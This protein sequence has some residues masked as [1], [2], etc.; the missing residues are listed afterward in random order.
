[1]ILDRS[2]PPEFT[3]PEDISLRTPDRKVLPNASTYYHIPTPAIEAVKIEFLGKGSRAS[4]PL[5]QALLP[6]FTLQMLTDGTDKLNHQQIA[7]RFDFHASEFQ[8]IVTFGQ[9]G[10]SLISTKKHVFEVLPL[11]LELVH[12]AVF[13]EEILEKKKSQRRI[14][15]QLEQKKTSAR[16]SKLFR[17]CL[18]GTNHPYGV[19]VTEDFLDEIT[20]DR[21]QTHFQ[22]F[23]WQDLE[24][25]VSGNF[26]DRELSQLE[27]FLNQFPVR[28]RFSDSPQPEQ[29]VKATLYEER[30][31]A[32]QTSLR[33]GKS[34]IPK[35][36]P[37][38][39][40]FSIFNTLLGGYFGSRL[41]KNIREDKG[42][43]YGIYS[44]IVQIG[45]RYYWQIAADVAKTH[46]PI[47]QEEIKKEIST[48][49]KEAMQASE[50]ESTR[51]F[52]LGSMLS[53]FSNSFE[54]MNQFRAVHQVGLDLNFYQ[55]KLEFIKSFDQE[56]ILRIG[57]NYFLDQ[58]LIEVSVG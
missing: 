47:V 52:L 17:K 21:L 8:P 40:P 13:P 23:L 37:D 16:S 57:Q 12:E 14:A 42:H 56:A 7:K 53:Q 22:E 6:S 20:R 31:D 54:S 9:E 1:M 44:S 33:M 55:Q 11:L 35:S 48:L 58:E 50:L 18:F 36:H 34:C 5:K 38:F 49:C 46:L 32:V 30:E 27:H 26:S 4:L 3:I 39:I 28:S 41:S 24:I 10:F 51:N 45:E 43:T 15:L 29:Q 19:E 25:F 2:T